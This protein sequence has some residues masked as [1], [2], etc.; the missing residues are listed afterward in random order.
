MFFFPL[1]TANLQEDMKNTLEEV[2]A[3]QGEVEA[4]TETEVELRERLVEEKSVVEGLR[5][6]LSEEYANTEDLR[7]QIETLRETTSAKELEVE[8]LLEREQQLKEELTLTSNVLACSVG[9]QAVTFYLGVRGHSCP[10]SPSE[11]IES[12]LRG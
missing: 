12:P 6:Q 7:E 4:L 5:E 1:I 2:E 9:F 8:D 3:L 10:L 11:K